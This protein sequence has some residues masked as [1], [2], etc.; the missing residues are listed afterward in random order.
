MVSRT[1]FTQEMKTLDQEMIQMGNLAEK[2]IKTG[3]KAFMEGD[4][5]YLEE[6]KKLDR[7]L[8][9]M[10]QTIEKHCLDIIALHQ[11]LAVD[12]RTVSSILK[13]IT[14]LNRIGRYGRDL[15]ETGD[16]DKSKHVPQALI[17]MISEVLSLVSDAIRSFVTRDIE[18]AKSI[19]NRDDTIDELWKQ[20]LKESLDYIKE[21]QKCK[22]SVSV[23]A[24]AILA[25]RYLERIADHACNIGDRV[26][27]MISGQRPDLIV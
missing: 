22:T 8:H 16:P 5:K 15:A 10:D 27:F 12:L 18:L 25:S 23:G 7:E 1:V 9:F 21:N 17:T 11:P 2:M 3:T 26:V 13:I 24:E 19:S 14:D 4:A 20:T 6:M